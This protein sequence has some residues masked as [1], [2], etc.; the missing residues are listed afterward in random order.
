MKILK[1]IAKVALSIA[2][3]RFFAGSESSFDLGGALVFFAACY[4][5]VTFYIWHFSN[6]GVVGVIGGGIFGFALALFLNL[7]LPL[8]VI[9]IPVMLLDTILPGEI[10]TIIGGIIVIIVC[11]GCI[12]GD[13]FGVVRLFKPDFLGGG[14]DPSDD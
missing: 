2:A 8:L 10:G 13:I 1:I 4:G 11:V 5:L 6:N 3:M 12:V 7:C 9:V 14:V